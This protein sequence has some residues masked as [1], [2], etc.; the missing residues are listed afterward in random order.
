[1][2]VLLPAAERAEFNRHLSRCRYC[3]GVVGEYRDIGRIIK[4]LPPRVEPQ[5][6]L[7][8][9]TVAAMAAAL[10]EQRAQADRRPDAEDQ[11]AT[12]VYLRSERQPLAEP[13]T[14]VRPIPQLHP[15]PEPETRGQQGPQFHLTAEPQARPW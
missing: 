13:E 11:A 1:M 14:R 10:A 7:E 3:Q 8:D 6:D 15:P 12:R 5:A 9:R 4:N 2:H